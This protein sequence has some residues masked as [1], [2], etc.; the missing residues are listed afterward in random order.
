MAEVYDT[1]VAP[2]TAPLMAL[3]DE[4]Y[5]PPVPATQVAA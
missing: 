3:T 1:Q 5:Y 2:L 4:V